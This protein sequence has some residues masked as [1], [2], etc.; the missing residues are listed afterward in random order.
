VVLSGTLSTSPQAGFGRR[1]VVTDIE[2]SPLALDDFYAYI[3]RGTY[4]QA[5]CP[6]G[7]SPWKLRGV[8]AY[9]GTG[10]APDTSTSTQACT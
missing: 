7:A 6:A 5:Q 10:Q 1:L 8:F 9:S 4:F 3:K 2:S